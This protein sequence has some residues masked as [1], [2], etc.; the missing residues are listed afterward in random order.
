MPRRRVTPMQQ[1]RIS[2]LM[3]QGQLAAIVG[4]SRPIIARFESGKDVPSPELRAT[5]ACVF[6]TV[7]ES[8][9]PPGE[10]LDRLLAS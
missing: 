7:P 3:T 10:V 6:G 2:R 9:W 5:I 1:L 4:V 8:L